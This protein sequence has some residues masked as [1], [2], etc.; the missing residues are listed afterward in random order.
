MGVRSCYARLARI[1]SDLTEH[2]QEGRPLTANLQSR[3]P[4]YGA[5]RHHPNA[6]TGTRRIDLLLAT[7]KQGITY[8]LSPDTERSAA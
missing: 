6:E 1:L 8:W 2:V 5:R 4:E 3:A 7:K